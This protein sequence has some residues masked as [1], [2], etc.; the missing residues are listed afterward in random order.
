MKAIAID[1]VIC[2]P[3]EIAKK[4]EIIDDKVSSMQRLPRIRNMSAGGEIR[5]EH[6]TTSIFEYEG[7]IVCGKSDLIIC[8]GN[9]SIV[10]VWEKFF[11]ANMAKMLPQDVNIINYD[12]SLAARK[13][14]FWL[15]EKVGE[16]D[17]AISL[18]GPHAEHWGH[19]LLEYVPRLLIAVTR[20]DSEPV[21]IL[22]PEG[23]DR[24]C[25]ELL[26]LVLSGYPLAKIVKVQNGQAIR[27]RRLISASKGV[28]LCDHSDYASQFDVVVKHWV[29]GA[30][31][32][33][34]S[35]SRQMLG[36]ESSIDIGR[37]IYVPRNSKYRGLT[38]GEEIEK[39][40][41]DSG[42]ETVDP[43]KLSLREKLE[44][45]GSAAEV[46]LV[47]SG[48]SINCVFMSPG[49]RMVSVSPHVRSHDHLC[50][51][52]RPDMEFDVIAGVDESSNVHTPFWVDQ[53]L[54]RD[55][56]R[57]RHNISGGE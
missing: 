32:S 44:V 18:L 56:M 9:S 55:A 42:F 11:L 21:G 8:E 13:I 25:E 47:A 14:S 50:P 6:P 5:L 49:S 37:R 17:T 20:M 7:A 16:I 28:H 54:V 23:I 4:H 41:I 3:E 51:T 34:I 36:V 12:R 57:R 35:L 38:N 15:P 2:T 27:C 24:N 10:A 1:G 31:Q 29:P 22:V 33:I 39:I 30:I 52:I 45:F 53:T 48:A 46:F 19:F 26:L 40:A 43:S